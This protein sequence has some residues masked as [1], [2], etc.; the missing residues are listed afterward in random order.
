[1]PEPVPPDFLADPRLELRRR[2]GEVFD[3]HL[4]VSWEIGRER[5]FYDWLARG[6][7]DPMPFLDTRRI[8]TEAY[9][10]RLCEL[11]DL[12]N[13]WFYWRQDVGIVFVPLTEWEAIS[14]A[15]PKLL[16]HACAEVQAYSG[17]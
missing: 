7:R 1:M 13:G 17:P 14:A 4:F 9:Y 6:T 5:L 16:D 8:I 12:A 2:M 15:W 3:N 11:H 10:N